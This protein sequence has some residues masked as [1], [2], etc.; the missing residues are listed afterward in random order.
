[1][2]ALVVDVD[3]GYEDLLDR[4][5]PTRAFR[6]AHPTTTTCS[7]PAHHWHAQ[8]RGVAAGGHLLRGDG[9]REPRRPAPIERPEDIRPSVVRNRGCA[10]ARSSPRMTPAGP[11]RA[12]RARAHGPRQR[13]V[14]DPRTLLG[15]G[16]VVLYSAHV[17]MA[18]V[19][20]L[21]ER[22]GVVSLNLVGDANA[23]PLLA[24]LESHPGRW[25]TSSVRLMGSG[26]AML[27]GDVGAA[28]GGVPDAARHHR[29]GRL[30]GR[31]CRR[32]G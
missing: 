14:V 17:D 3:D 18:T 20:D 24:A 27:S 21:I 4:A 28:D 19:L 8:G 12:A 30:L 23:R 32:C 16:K 13:P 26:G 22:E 31:R 15:G 10:L 29:G 11:V 1:M 5:D 25:D 2:V 6:T 7:T 9:R